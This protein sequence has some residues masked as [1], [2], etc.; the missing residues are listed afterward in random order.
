MAGMMEVPYVTAPFHKQDFDV[1]DAPEAPPLASITLATSGATDIQFNNL[2]DEVIDVAPPVSTKPPV[3]KRIRVRQSVSHSCSPPRGLSRRPTVLP[4]FVSA[5]GRPKRRPVLKII[6]NALC[7]VVFWRRGW[8]SNPR[9]GYPY[10]GFR[11]L[12]FSRRP[13]PLN[14]QP[15]A[16]VW[17]FRCSD[18]RL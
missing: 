14:S 7:R 1:Q 17:L 11:V 8:D 12:R 16:L 13:V 2:S 15:S 6:S 5:A 4:D 9:Y 10:N 3:M 18:P